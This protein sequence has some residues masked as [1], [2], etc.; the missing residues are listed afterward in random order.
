MYTILHTYMS[1]PRRKIHSQRKNPARSRLSPSAPAGLR[2]SLS[3]RQLLAKFRSLLPASLLASWLADAPQSFYDRAFTPLITL[4]YCI[5][6]RL[7]TDQ[8][9]GHALAD[10]RAGGA[11]RLS[12]RG[13]R[14]SQ[15][16]RSLAT[17]SL[18][19]ARQ[20]LPLEVFAQTLRRSAQQISTWTQEGRWRDWRVVLLDGSTFRLRPWGDIAQHFPPHRP[21]NCRKPPYWCVVRVLGAFC[22]QTG[23]VLDCALGSLK[24]SEQALTA[25]LLT[26]SW[27]KSLFVGDRNFGVYSVVRTITGA[28]AQA[29]VRL[30]KSRAAR[31]ARTAGLA[32]VQGLDAPLAWTPTPHDQCPEGLAR[33]PVAG[34]LLVLRVRR[35]GFPPLSL[36]LF[37]TLREAQ[38]YS[39]EALVQLYGQRWRVELCLRFVKTEMDLDFL[40]C[41]S[42]DMARKEWLAGLTAYNLI[43]STMVAAA[44][45]AQISVHILS[46]SRSRQLFLA[47]L[48]RWSI[49]PKDL[50][51]RWERLLKH[52]AQVRLPRR[53]KPRPPEP[54]A[55]RA[56][57]K[58]FPPLQ[59][60]RA[61][62]R[63]KLKTINAKS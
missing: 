48:L 22:L 5:F 45:Q 2:T 33:E 20:R 7:G 37:T 40:D 31:L 4:W 27:L 11:D 43:R 61:A 23:T 21:G 19:D 36:Y 1:T 51:Q 34:R 60:D 49:R 28:Q 8:T 18:S 10:A 54:R 15:Q 24:A 50:L 3:A 38:V 12:P 25:R 63:K 59:G 56:F 13:K 42:A 29:V 41:Q 62:A 55:I 35:P 58:Y 14:L 46:F 53:R 6:Q 9:L 26:G 30:T 32:L 44:A 17:T 47:W 52:I 39:P 57:Q 16:L